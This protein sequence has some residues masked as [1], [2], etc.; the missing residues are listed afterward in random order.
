MAGLRRVD[1]QTAQQLEESHSFQLVSWTYD[2][3]GEHRDIDQDLGDIDRAIALERASEED[4]MIASSWKRRF[5]IRLFQVADALPFALPGIATEEIEVHLRDYF[6]YVRNADGIAELAREKLKTV[7]RKARQEGRPVLLLAHSMGSVIAIDALWQLSRKEMSEAGVDCLVTT[8]SPLGQK[9]VQRHLLS[10]GE[11]AE[12]RYPSNIGSWVNIAAVG[13]LTAIDRNL[14][15][16]FSTMIQLGL[17]PGIDDREVF[18]YYRMHRTLNVHAEYGYL[19]ND[20][21]ARCVSDWW[22]EKSG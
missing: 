1:P 13:E 17:V 2:F 3:Y 16:D 12:S 9:I 14:A 5:L 22:R 20:A 7:L 18:N 11:P 6:R 15:N 19:V 4:I 10:A 8:G 21:I